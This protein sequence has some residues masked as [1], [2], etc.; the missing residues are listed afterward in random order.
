[1]HGT[2]S[3]HLQA[4]EL[5]FKHRIITNQLKFIARNLTHPN[6]IFQTV[7]Q[8]DRNISTRGSTERNLQTITPNIVTYRKSFCYNG[9]LEWNKLPADLNAPQSH[10]TFKKKLKNH[11]LSTYAC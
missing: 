1:M 11:F 7:Q 8:S 3:L 2:N 10:P 6:P 9:V 5:T 4:K